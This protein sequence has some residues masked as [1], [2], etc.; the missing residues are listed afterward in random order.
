M[1][2]NREYHCINIQVMEA[3]TKGLNLLLKLMSIKN[4]ENLTKYISVV[5]LWL[6]F[7]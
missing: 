6:I 4:K 5:S 7:N 2:K 3:I 1:H